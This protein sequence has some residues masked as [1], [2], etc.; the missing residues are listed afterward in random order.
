MILINTTFAV[1]ANIADDFVDFI[2]STYIPLADESGFHSHLL[3]RMRAPEDINQLTNQPTKTFALQ[4]RAPSQEA[5]EEFRRDILPQLYNYIG[6]NWGMSVAMF[7]ST[8]DVIHDSK[9][10]K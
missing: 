5:I 4:M 10:E 9:K 1:D 7:E 3:T 6:K 2:R 8:L